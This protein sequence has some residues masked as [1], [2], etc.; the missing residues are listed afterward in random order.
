ME[1][2]MNIQ[3]KGTITIETLR[4][5]L[6]RFE[7]K[8]AKAMFRNWAG[9]PEV[10]KYLSWGPHSNE[11]ISRKRVLIWINNY[12]MDNSYLWALELK[13]TGEAV[14]SIS[15]EIADDRTGTCEV[16]YCLGRKYWK[17]GLMTEALLAIQ[18]YLF[19]EIGYQTIRAKHDVLNIASGRVMQKA[20][21]KYN[22]TEHKVGVR[23]DGTYYDCDVYIKHIDEE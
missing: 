3:H 5:V 2:R 17:Q 1:V 6:R 21:M 4:L 11:E 16:G 10:C 13:R 15:V 19:Y 23:R 18:H 14:G 20:G 8:D 22:K 12:V 7:E 9:D